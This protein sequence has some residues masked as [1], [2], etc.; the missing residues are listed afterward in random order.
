MIIKLSP[1]GKLLNPL[2]KTPLPSQKLLAGN[3]STTERETT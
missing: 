3:L 1:P 2:Y